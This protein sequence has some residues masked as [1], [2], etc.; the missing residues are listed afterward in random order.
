LFN[1]DLLAS[2]TVPDIAHALFI[3]SCVAVRL[4]VAN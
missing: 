2:F 4:E 3:E 1:G